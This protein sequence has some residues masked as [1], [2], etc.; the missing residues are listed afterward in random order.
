ME[1][2]EALRAAGVMGDDDLW[3][4]HAQEDDSVGE[5]EDGELDDDPDM[6]A[7]PGLPSRLHKTAPAPPRLRRV[8]FAVDP[9]QDMGRGPQVTQ[10]RSRPDPSGDGLGRRREDDHPPPSAVTKAARAGVQPGSPGGAAKRRRQTSGG[11]SPV[12]RAK[13]GGGRS[14]ADGAAASDAHMPA[15]GSAGHSKV[16]AADALMQLMEPLGSE[17]TGP[18]TAE[19]AQ[20]NGGDLPAGGP[21]QAAEPANRKR[22]R[23]P[24]AKACVT[25]DQQQAPKRKRGR[26]PKAKQSPAGVHGN[27][28]RSASLADLQTMST[29]PQRGDLDGAGLDTA[30]M[31]LASQKQM[32]DIEAALA[33][34]DDL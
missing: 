33:E 4:D 6:P 20:Q 27:A 23:P 7:L 26:P 16:L 15:N 1:A 17:S 32:A 25:D 13:K 8:A 18:P 14:R 29:V 3:V 31:L 10:Q 9:A 5:L 28:N 12:K 30:A 11:V 24:K 21:L 34:D 2:R 22:G 19:A